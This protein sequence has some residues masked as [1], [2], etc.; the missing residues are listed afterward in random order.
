M[1]LLL[2]STEIQPMKFSRFDTKTL[3]NWKLN[4]KRVLRLFFDL[5][6]VYYILYIYIY[7]ILLSCNIYLY[8]IYIYILYIHVYIYNIKLL[9]FS[10][11]KVNL[12]F[13]SCFE[14]KDILIYIYIY[15]YQKSSFS[16]VLIKQRRKG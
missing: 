4:K 12:S 6:N 14:E 2:R 9:I 11:F 15:I 8:I 3:Q 13:L 5:Y 16:F 10:F 7:Y 1:A